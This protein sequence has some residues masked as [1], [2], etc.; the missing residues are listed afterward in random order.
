MSASALKRLL[1][2]VRSNRVVPRR[3]P[4]ILA[5]LLLASAAQAQPVRRHVIAFLPG[6]A[7]DPHSENAVHQL[8]ETPLNYLGIVVR[9]HY[10]ESGPPPDG[11]LRDA[12]AVLTWFDADTEPPAWLW[13]WLE[14]EVPKR[15]LRVVHMGRFG[16]LSRDADRLDRWLARLGL[17]WEDAYTRDPMRVAV[18]FRDEK[19]C[20]FETDPRRRAVHEG[21]RIVDKKNVA[22]VTTRDRFSKESLCHPVVLGSWGAVALNPWCVHLGDGEGDRR[23]HLDPFTFFRTALGM[24]RIPAPHPAVLN[25]RR[26][27]FCQVDGDGFES[28]STVTHG[29]FNAEVM[30]DQVFASYKLPFTVSIIVRSLTPDLQV[31]QATPKMELAR[32]ILRMPNIEPASHGVLHTQE[33]RRT[34]QKHSAPRAIKWYPSI[35]NYVYSQVSEVRDSIRF[36]NERLLDRPRRCAVMLWT[37]EANPLAEPLAAVDEAGCVNLNGGVFRWDAWHDSLA[38]VSPWSRRVGSALQVYA[39]A[40]NENA[41]AGFFD[42]MPGAFRHIDTTIERTGTPRIL[43]PADVYV[44]FYSAEK[45]A[46]LKAM[47]EV[48]ERWTRKEPTAPVFASTYARAVTSAIDTARVV[49]TPAGWRFV[50]FGH[51]RSVRIDDEK[52]DVD[53]TRSKGVLGARRYGR[54]LWIHLAQPTAEVVLATQPPRRPHIEQA[55]C[56]LEDPARGAKGMA[57]TA[58]ASGP[59]IVVFAGLPRDR[60]V[61]LLLDDVHRRPRTDAAGRLTVR[62]AEP[63]RTKVVVGE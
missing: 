62:L 5:L 36:V 51:C 55:N 23:W 27:W 1:G 22:W 13:P 63:G 9:H 40:A 43:K 26:M 20:A 50:N 19:L 58:V 33:W 38:F 3:L 7:P 56:L 53:F 37:G 54:R 46:R 31:E 28:V 6:N 4:I 57:V 24:E 49:R 11:W 41:F 59:R 32:T 45:P 17:K 30:R 8:F 47:K 18:E 39:G 16:P 25:G 34:L 15:R 42:T 48:L 60:D 21:P 14:R 12:R 10:I 61:N 52:R 29:A 2:A 44:H 35:D